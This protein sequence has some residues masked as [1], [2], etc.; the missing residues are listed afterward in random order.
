MV[1]TFD[2][3]ARDLTVRLAVLKFDSRM[4]AFTRLRKRSLWIRRMATFVNNLLVEWRKRAKRL[5]DYLCDPATA[6]VAGFSESHETDEEPT[7]TMFEGP[8]QIGRAHV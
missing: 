7:T 2:S 4:Q 8:A 3:L 1:A 6:N 5:A